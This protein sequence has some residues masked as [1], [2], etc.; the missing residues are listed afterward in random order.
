[1]RKK[2]TGFTLIEL[3]VVIAIIALLLS[4]LMPALSKVKEMAR[5]IVCASGLRQDGQAV[6]AYATDYDGRIPPYWDRISTNPLTYRPS[7]SLGPGAGGIMSP[8]AR[9]LRWG[10]G[11]LVDEPFGWGT[12]GYLP[13]AETL[14]CPSDRST[15]F[16][17]WTKREKGE[18]HENGW[19]SYWY[20]HFH[21]EDPTEPALALINRYKIGK[22]SGKAVILIEQ[23]DWPDYQ[24]GLSVMYPSYHP[25]GYNILHLGGR[26]NFVRD[27]LYQEELII[28]KARQ[29]YV[30]RDASLWFWNPKFTVL[31]N[32]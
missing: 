19:M 5:I 20:M 32:M 13:D 24:P 1:M 26:V 7:S 31:D 18:F 28:E 17:D 23:G 29:K 9:D 14:I 10:I 11:M 3:L 15:N 2:H 27:D 21:P 4:I 22:S 16:Y 8:V 25:K 6:N 12:S 30:G